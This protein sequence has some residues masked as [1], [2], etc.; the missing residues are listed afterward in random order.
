[1]SK[2]EVAILCLMLGYFSRLYI[3]VFIK[4]IS[5]AWTEYLKDKNQNED[6]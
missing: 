3:E 5:N 2:I 1:M 6:E 4:I